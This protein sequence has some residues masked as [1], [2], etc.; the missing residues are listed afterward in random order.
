MVLTDNKPLVKLFGGRPLDEIANI[1]LFRVKQ[2]SLLWRLKLLH[3]PRKL[4]FDPDT[5]S[6]HPVETIYKTKDEV[7][8]KASEILAGIRLPDS[9]C[10]QVIKLVKIF[11]L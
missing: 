6:R 9:E 2:R 10:L 4:H 8:I 3:K 1:R 5:M 11:K 7:E